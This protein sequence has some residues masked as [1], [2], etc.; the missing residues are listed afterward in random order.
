MKTEKRHSGICKLRSVYLIDLRRHM[1]FLL[2]LDVRAANDN[3][4]VTYAHP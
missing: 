2:G 4:M 1:G 3:R